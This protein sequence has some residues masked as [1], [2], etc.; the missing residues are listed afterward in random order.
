LTTSIYPIN[1]GKLA[2]ID[3][4]TVKLDL[5]DNITQNTIHTSYII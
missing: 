4:I 3:S 1:E 2:N 5:I